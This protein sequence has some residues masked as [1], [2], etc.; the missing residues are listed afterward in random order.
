[1]WSRKMSFIYSVPAI[2]T[3]PPSVAIPY[4]NTQDAE[5]TL[6]CTFV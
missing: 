3:Q 2:I 6:P 5:G 4:H 1:M